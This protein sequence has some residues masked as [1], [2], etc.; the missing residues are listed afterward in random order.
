MFG[1][2]MELLTSSDV[3]NSAHFQED[4]TNTLQKFVRGPR[5]QESCDARNMY[6]SVNNHALLSHSK[7]EN[8]ILED[9]D[10]YRQAD[11]PFL[12][13]LIS[14]YSHFPNTD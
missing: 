6:T 3:N 14:L 4:N 12:C 8:V 5:R 10:T 13:L 1:A 7:A 9:L 2:T 11:N